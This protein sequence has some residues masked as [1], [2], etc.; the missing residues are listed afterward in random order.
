M[1][2]R[3][4]S[5]VLPSWGKGR[6]AI[7]EGGPRGEA[8]DPL[9]W[10]SQERTSV[11][12]RPRRDS[13][14]H[15]RWLWRLLQMLSLSSLFIICAMF[16]ASSLLWQMLGNWEG[17]GRHALFPSLP[18][19]I[20]PSALSGKTRQQPWRRMAHWDSAFWYLLG[21]ILAPASRRPLSTEL[22]LRRRAAQRR[23]CL[24][25]A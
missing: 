15:W 14:R 2:M 6:G 12:A 25:Q 22:G 20:P 1:G 3:V 24:Y 21:L 18:G 11:G 23:L 7:G 4:G 5:V 17:A 16:S 13:R 9:P 10:R 8:S 19:L